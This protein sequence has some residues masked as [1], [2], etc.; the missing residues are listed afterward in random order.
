MKY[1][2][3]VKRIKSFEEHFRYKPRN[4]DGLLTLEHKQLFALY[5]SSYY[6]RNAG[7]R[8]RHNL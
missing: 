8:Q 3:E 5:M 4:V 7:A 2:K 6:D 1:I